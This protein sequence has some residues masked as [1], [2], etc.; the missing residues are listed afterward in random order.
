MADT[1]EKI[2]GQAGRASAWTEKAGDQAKKVTQ[3]AAEKAHEA[4]SGVV[5]AVKDK[6]QD[7]V[8]G[9]SELAGKV[10]DTAQEWASSVGDAAVGAKD[11]AVELTREAA[12]KVEDIGQ[13]VTA[14]VR[15]YPLQ[16]M[17]VGF[18]V[19]FLVAQVMRRS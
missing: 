4:T 13:D 8:T 12:S 7:V 9:A 1:K 15:R 19:G 16:S 18:G 6:V 5:G 10:K 3:A 17:L 14:L 2:D 11:K